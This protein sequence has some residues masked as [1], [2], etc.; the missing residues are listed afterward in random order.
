M[1]RLCTNQHCNTFAARAAATL[2]CSQQRQAPLPTRNGLKMRCLAK[3]CFWPANCSLLAADELIPVHSSGF[4][5]QSQTLRRPVGKADT[6]TVDGRRS[7]HEN[8]PSSSAALCRQTR[9]AQR[10]DVVLLF[11]LAIV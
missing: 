10:P 5:K 8:G 3:S 9:D 7:M 4:G 1:H 6:P 2:D 11:W